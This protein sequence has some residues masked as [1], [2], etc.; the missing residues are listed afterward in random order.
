MTELVPI[1][2]T[3]YSQHQKSLITF[4]FSKSLYIISPINNTV[5]SAFENPREPFK[6]ETVYPV[7]GV[8]EE[9]G[10]VFSQ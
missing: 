5:Y 7:T 8:T 3:R 9:N 2:L 10:G 4:R 1:A 6:R